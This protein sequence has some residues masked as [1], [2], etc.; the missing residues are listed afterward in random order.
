MRYISALPNHTMRDLYFVTNISIARLSHPLQNYAYNIY[1]YTLREQ[2]VPSALKIHN[3]IAHIGGL[4]LHTQS[5]AI[6]FAFAY[7]LI[8]TA[9]PGWI[10][11]LYMLSYW[12]WI[13]QNITSGIHNFTK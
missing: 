2:Y 9:A 8:K 7:M 6:M 3:F 13:I 4:Y 1:P 5:T 12:Q 10:Y 11:F